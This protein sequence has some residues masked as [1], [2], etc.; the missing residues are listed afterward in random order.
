[1]SIE[2]PPVRWLNRLVVLQ[3]TP[4][5]DEQFKE[6]IKFA[7]PFVLYT[8]ESQA[9]GVGAAIVTENLVGLARETRRD[10]EIKGFVMTAAKSMLDGHQGW[11]L[12]VAFHVFN[13]LV[14]AKGLKVYGFTREKDTKQY[15]MIAKPIAE[16]K[17][18]K[19][20]M[21]EGYMPSLLLTGIVEGGRHDEGTD[22]ED[23]HGLQRL[24][25]PDILKLSRSLVSIN[26]GREIAYIIVGL[27]GGFRLQS[28]NDD[29]RYPTKEGLGTY[30]GIPEKYIPH[31]QMEA[32]VGTIILASQIEERFGKNWMQADRKKDDVLVQAVNDYVMEEGALLVPPH[33]RGVYPEAV[34][35]CATF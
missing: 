34:D 3:K 12:Q 27:H 6:A 16:F 7:D 5:F 2:L 8:H 31:V 33:A 14:S 10:N 21:M 29:K 22:P 9:D 15:G 1:M 24:T 13:M 35:L 23:I 11:K 4:G 18:M 28:P 26:N 19:R 32:N 30:F 25:G 20:K 17:P